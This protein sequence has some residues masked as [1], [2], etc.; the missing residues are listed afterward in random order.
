MG[1]GDPFQRPLP[2]AVSIGASFAADFL[3]S[4]TPYSSEPWF[5]GA[6]MRYAVRSR[7]RGRPDGVLR[8]TL[9]GSAPRSHGFP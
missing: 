9:P 4:E 5:R 8:G 2:T 7:E 3:L 6:L 1:E